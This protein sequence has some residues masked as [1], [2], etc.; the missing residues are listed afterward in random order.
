MFSLITC[1]EDAWWPPCIFFSCP[2]RK[3]LVATKHFLQL[4]I[5]KD[6]AVAK[7]FR[8]L[9]VEKMPKGHRAFFL[10]PI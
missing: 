1:P 2:S 6:L 8:Q 4:P 9:L 10:L 5:Q 7:P 3:P